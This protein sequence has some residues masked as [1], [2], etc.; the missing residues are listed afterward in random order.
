MHS[1]KDLKTFLDCL[2]TNI[3]PGA[4]PARQGMLTVCFWW[5]G[6]VGSTGKNPMGKSDEFK[7][8]VSQQIIR[9]F[10]GKEYL[11]IGYSC[12][13]AIPIDVR[14]EYNR[15]RQ[16]PCGQR[17]MKPQAFRLAVQTARVA[18]SAARLVI[19]VILAVA[20]PHLALPADR[21]YSGPNNGTFSSPFNWS[22][23]VVPVNGD[24]AFVRSGASVNYDTSYSDPGLLFLIVD[25]N[26]G[27]NTTL[28]QS[29]NTTMQA[30]TQYIAEVDKGTYTQSAGTNFVGNSTTPGLIYI[31]KSAGSVGNYNLNGGTLSVLGAGLSAEEHIGESGTGT[32]T[33][34]GGTNTSA[35]EYIGRMIGASGTYMQSAGT[36]TAGIVW[37]GTGAGVGTCTGTYILSGTGSLSVATNETM[38]AG[39]FGYFTQNGGTNVTSTLNVANS[40][41]HGEYAL[42]SGSLSAVT[43]VVGATGSGLFTQTGG[44]NSVSGDLSLQ[45]GGVG[46]SYILQGGNLT[47]GS[48]TLNSGSGVF[49]QSGG[50]LN[51]AAFNQGGG[52]VVGTLQNQGTFNYNS[53]VFNGRL[54]N[55]GAVI[56]NADFIAANGMENDTLVTIASGR[57][58]TLNGAGLDNE[59]V[60]TVAAGGVL[61]LN[62]PLSNNGQMTANA[63]LTL[64]SS[65]TNAG[66]L[67]LVSGY[68]LSLKATTL[69]NNGSL[70][71]G[72]GLINGSGG[73]LVNTFGGVV[74][75][76][77]TITSSFSNSGGVLAPIGGAINVTQAFTNSGTIQLS[78]FNAGLTG[79]AITNTGSIQG[80]GTVSNAVIN[81][82]GTIEAIGGT[83]VLGG[84]LSNQAGGLFRIGSGSK[85]LVSAGLATNAGI[86]NLT[87]GTFDNAGTALNNS[88]Q[89][90]GYGVLSTGGLTN[91]GSMTLT[92]GT[93][94]VNGPVTNAASKTINIR[95]QP[96]IFTG[97]VTNNGTIKTTNT[98]VTFTGTY[99]GNV[100]ISDP[101]DNIFQADVTVIPGGTMTGG[102]G[103][104]FFMSGGSFTN[105]GTFS[106]GGVLQS[107]DAV[108][109]DGSFVQTG[110]LTQ[111]ANF[112]N[113]GTATIGGVQNWSSGTSFT[114]TAGTATFQSDAG[115][116]SA[117]PLMVN[118]NGGTVTF[119]APQH[120]AALS[121]GTAANAKLQSGL[122][123][124]MQLGA[125]T[126][127]GG[128]SPNG[129]LDVTDN[130]VVLHNGVVSTTLAQLRNGLNSSGTLWTG[131]GI[132]SSTAAADAA[133]HGNTTVFAVGAIKNADKFGNPIYSTWP[134]PPSPDGGASGLTTTDVLVKYT[135]F[136]DAD[137]NG[138]VD[139]TTDY[140]LWSNGFTNPTLA[141]T[142]GWLYGDFD[143]SGIVDN[144]TDY[145]L[146]STGFAHQGAPAAAGGTH[147]NPGTVTPARDLQAVPEPGGLML[148]VFGLVGLGLGARRCASPS[149]MQ[150][151]GQ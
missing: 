28:V 128:V 137:L 148:I 149:L 59:G 88:G 115:S 130:N 125:L 39:G 87:G 85:I 99:A 129:Q 3:C 109:T 124:P 107:S 63:N 102:S 27:S 100:Y 122:N 76:T 101:S 29:T 53:G 134:A 40:G 123:A 143:F 13:A 62:G 72:G 67:N 22:T 11:M 119:A 68:Q 12:A 52:T 17:L 61:N 139:N 36:N 80:V 135:Y 81:S 41:G 96:A 26:S 55:Q 78:A 111:S 98:T 48:V 116:A 42:N 18:S 30:V 34:M 146:W 54:L 97:N 79:G 14:R 71:L 15:Q 50:T 93:T 4:R 120:L 110:T 142:N 1:R 126:I 45:G 65:S 141:A 151:V 49:T 133:A 92:G 73:M 21:F 16:G 147:G 106:N 145:D 7:S 94:T 114:N 8:T 144:T 118:A 113:S 33:Q 9:P 57:T 37:L 64:S 6:I 105:H 136:G 77:G 117:A 70:N 82:T 10:T 5:H 75:G 24:R 19:A 132:Q 35:V 86:I 74:S 140:D 69:T 25:G 51:A 150:L 103:D 83:L 104:R 31:G 46:S 47:A 58:V 43:E 32:L 131:A 90:T 95:Y 84:T 38:G 138:V 112:T 66:T 127:A 89:I 20:L 108:S 23:Q 121:V 91:N 44:S 2:E 56:F 60:F